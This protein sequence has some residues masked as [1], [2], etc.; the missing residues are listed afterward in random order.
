MF[1]PAGLQ[2]AHIQ[3]QSDGYS[4]WRHPHLPYRIWVRD[5][6]SYKTVSSVKLLLA[7]HRART[8]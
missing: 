8:I 4:D 7:A 5:H 6:W 1:D 3:R 2:R